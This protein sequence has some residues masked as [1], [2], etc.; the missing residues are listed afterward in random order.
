MTLE[1]PEWL[2]AQE[3]VLYAYPPTQWALQTREGRPF[4]RSQLDA[5]EALLSGQIL[6]PSQ[7]LYEHVLLTLNVRRLHSIDRDIVLVLRAIG[8]FYALQNETIDLSKACGL[9]AGL[10]LLSAGLQVP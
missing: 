8:D 2:L 6:P 7:L 9:Y 1:L 3:H 5:G 4:S 10:L